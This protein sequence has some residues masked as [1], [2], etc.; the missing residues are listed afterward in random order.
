MNSTKN[1]I[2][3]AFFSG[4]TAVFSQIVIPLPTPVPFTLQIIAVC[5]SGAILGSKL[6]VMSQIVY[7]L[8]GSIGIPVFAGMS[9]GISILVGPTGG[10]LLSFPL[11]AG[12][13]GLAHERSQGV[14]TSFISMFISLVLIYSLGVAQLKFASSLSWRLAF[15]YGAAPFILLDML[16]VG[17]AVFVSKTI[18]LALLKN[19]LHPYNRFN[20]F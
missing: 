3:I 8:L 17:I 13:I 20:S 7:L 2:L 14:L 18:N 12:L 10:F 16:K 19:N 6:A 1:M 5:L 11:A 9:G 4:I 15:A